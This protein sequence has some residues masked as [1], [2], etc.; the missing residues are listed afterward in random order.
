MAFTKSIL[1][2]FVTTHSEIPLWS[3]LTTC[4]LMSLNRF[5]GQLRHGIRAFFFWGCFVVVQ[6]IRTASTKKFL[7][8]SAATRLDAL[9]SSL[10]TRCC[11]T[12]LNFLA[13]V[14]R[15]PVFW[16]NF[17]IGWNIKEVSTETIL[18]YWHRRNVIVPIN[19][20][21]G[22]WY[23]VTVYG[24]QNGKGRCLCSF[25]TVLYHSSPKNHF[26]LSPHMC[27]CL[28][29]PRSAYMFRLIPTLSGI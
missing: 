14:S 22:Q 12:S 28:I 19:S 11:R 26:D 17:A 1:I 29:S 8:S 21:L 9:F 27:F 15:T 24:E 6:S 20:G 25:S 10:P 16:S 23:D 4:I 13:V 18:E 3:S 2:S 7:I 5:R